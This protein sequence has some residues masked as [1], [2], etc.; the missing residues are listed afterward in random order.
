MSSTRFRLA[1]ATF[2]LMLVAVAGCTT[3]EGVHVDGADGASAGGVLN[4]A[5]GGEPDQL[6]PHKTSAYYSFQVLENVYD[7]LVEPDANLE[8]QP[9]LATGWTTSDDQLTWTFTLR[10]GVRFSDGSPLTAEDV[11]YSYTRII[12]EKL[13]TAYKFATVRSVTA[14]DPTT[15]VVALTAPTPNLLANLG[16]FKGVAIVQKANIESGEVTTK[17]V[18]SGPFAIGSYTSGDNI[19]L[20]RNDNYWGE[21]P[22]VDGV[23]FTFVSDPT[24]ALQNLRGGEV[25]WTDNL[26]PQQVP[27]LLDADELTV[28]SVPST[29]Y[30]YLALNQ[31]RKP[32]DNV[33]VRRAIAF[34]LDREAITKAAK[35]G[36]ATVNQTAISQNSAYHYEYAP[37]TH[38]ANQARQLLDQAGVS[39]L[40][41][42]LMVTTEYPETVTA[43]QVIASQLA[44]IGVTVKIR[45]L[46][47]AQWLDEQGN[48]NFD[49]FMLGWLGNIDPDEFYYAQHHSGGTFNFHKYANP[50]VDRLLDQARTETDQ[51]ARKQRY[52]Q[53]AKQIV[54][55]A[56]YIYLYNPD[57][58]QGWSSGLTGYEVRTDRAIRFRDAALA[59]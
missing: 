17:P 3:G 47:F 41:L 25:H 30:W 36:L 53:V 21:K 49:A 45:T 18:G 29:D 57:V 14:P 8:M 22:K 33:A 7:T 34:A 55:D 27:A 40:T 54:D 23:T 10:E 26:P 4:A 50:T 6:D 42:D 35:F 15:V 11:V 44:E 5:I 37:Y 24:V 1:G 32:Y 51:G 28:R 43:A 52:E 56:S 20:V 9:A 38:D 48:G 13:N 12:D 16:G 58:A 59:K 39:G 2:T 19:R 46:D 31:A